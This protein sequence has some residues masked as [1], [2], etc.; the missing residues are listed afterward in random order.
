MVEIATLPL[1]SRDGLSISDF[2]RPSL[3]MSREVLIIGA[4]LEG[5]LRDVEKLLLGRRIRLQGAIKPK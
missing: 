1:L 2:S 5:I 4:S 3:P